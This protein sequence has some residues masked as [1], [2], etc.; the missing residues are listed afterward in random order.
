MFRC[1]VR[2]G[3]KDVRNGEENFEGILVERLKEFI[4]EDY[5]V[6]IDRAKEGGGDEDEIIV[7]EENEME[8]LEKAW[9]CTW[10][11]SKRWWRRRGRMLQRGC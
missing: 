1:V 7:T 10:W 4:K 6:C 5:L 3:Y 8:K 11:G 9:R 2:Y